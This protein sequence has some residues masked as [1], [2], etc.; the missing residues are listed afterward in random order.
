[1]EIG[2]G[3]LPRGVVLVPGTQKERAVLLSCGFISRRRLTELLADILEAIC[4]EY[5]YVILWLIS[6]FAMCVTVILS[7]ASG[8]WHTE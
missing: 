5:I 1:M 8:T 2:I 3:T 4:G 6:Y 7:G